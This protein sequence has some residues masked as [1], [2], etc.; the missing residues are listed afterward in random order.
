MTQASAAGQSGQ[1]LGEEDVAPIAARLAKA[2]GAFARAYPGES[3]ARQPAHTVYLAPQLFD[4]GTLRAQGDL[5]LAAMDEHAASPGD[6]ARALG[7]E[8]SLEVAT[9][10]R[11]RVVAKL[12][13]EP[14]EDLRLDFEDGYGVRPD[15]E[16]D[17]HARSAAEALRVCAA[18]SR[19]SPFY[20]L[21]LKPLNE[22]CRARSVRT[23]DVFLTALARG[24]APPPGLRITLAKVT[25]PEQVAAM[26]ELLE[27]LERKLA[28]PEGS[29]R[30][31]IMIEVAQAVID[32]TGTPCVRR[33]VDAGRGRCFAAHLGT[34]D[35]TASVGVTA[36]HQR[37]SHPACDFAKHVMQVSL[38][39]TGVEICDGSTMALPEG[40]RK[41]WRLHA[42]DVR[43]SL[44]QGFYQGWDLYPVQL[45][46]RFG[47]LYAFFQEALPSATARMRSFL[48]KASQT[49][50]QAPSASGFADDAATGQALLG[51]FLRGLACG[52]ITS[53]EARG[54]GLTAEEL[55]AR[56]FSAVLASRR[57]SG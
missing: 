11:E 4:T 19:L 18:S 35:Y 48:S 44:S 47:A 38:A 45:A 39:G 20:G 30:F 33:L 42:D 54:A 49:S 27:L 7:L 26:A 12:R 16:E 53:E 37:M 28:L 23:L 34:Y 17:H 40:V 3:S 55:Q 14:I 2:N 36:A 52:A 41:A 46:S 21:R 5:A 25:V 13:R 8:V 15:A 32:A 29:L 57:K 51:F 56:S 9:V 43:R 50:S 31:E 22:D 24:G 10:V 1:S 6:F